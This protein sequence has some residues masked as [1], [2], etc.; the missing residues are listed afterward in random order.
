MSSPSLP[1]EAHRPRDV[2]AGGKTEEQTFFTE[3]L[4]DTPRVRSHSPPG[5]SRLSP[6]ASSFFIGWLEAI[7]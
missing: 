4:I 5:I 2:D 6:A 7:R 1:G 3:K